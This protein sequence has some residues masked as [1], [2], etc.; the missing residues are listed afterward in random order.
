MYGVHM[1]R[2]ICHN[3]TQK[4][5]KKPPKFD[6]N[7]AFRISLLN[8]QGAGS[9]VSWPFVAAQKWKNEIIMGPENRIE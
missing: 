5:S 7:W 3:L 6:R 1:Y 8:A 9:W 2:Y 4:Q